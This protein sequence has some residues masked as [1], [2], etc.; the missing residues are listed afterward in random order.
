MNNMAK[1]TVSCDL[2][3]LEVIR[4]FIQENLNEIP[5]TCDITSNQIVLAVDEACANSIIHGNHCDARKEL[6]I[7]IY[8]D[9][10]NDLH[11]NLYD[12]S[13]P[14]DILSYKMKDIREKIR[15]AE[16]GGMGICLIQKIMDEITIEK[17]PDFCIYK[18]VKHLNDP[19][20][21]NP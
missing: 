11:I 8:K 2:K 19:I 21:P 15:N 7:E 4:G 1:L 3:N 20:K 17:Y 16:S 5:L 13:P 9:E 18:F 12:T 14:F 10:M 6:S